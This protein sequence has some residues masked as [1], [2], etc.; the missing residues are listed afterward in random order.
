MINA[1]FSFATKSTQKCV[2]SDIF[3]NE[4]EREICPPF[5]FPTVLTIAYGRLIDDANLVSILEK[6]KRMC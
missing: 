5:K 6:A 4:L 1:H 3:H 2:K